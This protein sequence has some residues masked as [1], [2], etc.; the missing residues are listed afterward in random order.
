MWI[1]ELKAGINN[2]T[3]FLNNNISWEWLSVVED[4]NTT[5]KNR[6]NFWVQEKLK[7]TKRIL[8][9]E[10]KVKGFLKKADSDLYYHDS[11]SFEYFLSS[12]KYLEVEIQLL[13]ESWIDVS[14]YKEKYIKLRKKVLKKKIEII[15][16]E[17]INLESNYELNEAINLLKKYI[18]ELEK[19]WIDVSKYEEKIYDYEYQIDLNNYII[20]NP[21]F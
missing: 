17:D 4:S 1:D 14:K 15:Y 11:F 5:A 18:Q 13:K 2:S 12:V 6:I 21:N 3:N 10:K 16:N 19:L 9:L 7:E 20:Y 8:T